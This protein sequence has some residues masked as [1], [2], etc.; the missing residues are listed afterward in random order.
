MRAAVLLYRLPALLY[1]GLL[2]WLSSRPRLPEVDLGLGFEDKLAHFAAYALFSILLY[3]ALTRPT[4]WVRRPHLWAVI[5][6]VLYALT[7]EWHQSTVPGRLFEVGDL[8][9]DAAGLVAIQWLIYRL[10][11]RR[12][13]VAGAAPTEPPPP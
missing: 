7:D 8:V 13:S 1:A 6:G 5:L 2:Y 9:A 10:E 3:L 11:R 4:P 12:R